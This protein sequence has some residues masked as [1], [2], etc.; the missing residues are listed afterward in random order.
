M[1]WRSLHERLA[2]YAVDGEPIGVADGPEEGHVKANSAVRGDDGVVRAG[3]VVARWSGWSLATMRPPFDAGP[4]APGAARGG[5]LPFA[6]DFAFTPRPG[7]L[8]ALRFAARYAV[9]ARV[10]DIAGGGLALDDAVADRCAITQVSYARYEPVASPM[11]L[12][13]DG[14]A[15]AALGPAEAVDRVVVRSGPGVGVDAFDAANPGY[16]THARR[17]LHRPHTSLEIAEQHKLLDGVD[18]ERAFA[19]V[20]RALAA[21][22]PGPDPADGPLPDPAAG[23][24]QVVPRLDPGAPAA[25][26]ASRDWRGPW[27][28]PDEPKPLELRDRAAGQAPVS[29][30]EQTLVVRLAAGEQLTLEL[31]SSLTEDFFDHFALRHDPSRPAAEAGR[32]PL[33]TPARTV[34][35]VH[36]VRRPLR[37]VPAATLLVSRAPEA[38]QTFAL[39]DPS[40]ALVGPAGLDA[41]S[42]AQLDV[43][44]AWKERDDDQERDIAAAPVQSLSIAPGDVALNGQLRH[45]LGDTR[46]RDITYTLSGVSRFRQYFAT[47][48]DPEAFCARTRLDTTV[49][50]LSTARPGPPLVLRARPAFTVKETVETSGGATTLRRQRLA[51]GLR[52]E[53]QRPWFTTGDGE[54]L[55]VI[56]WDHVGVAPPATLKPYVTQA[57][58]DPVWQTPD[59]A[60]WPVEARSPGSRAR[61]DGRRL[62]RPGRRCSRCPSSR[63][64][65]PIAGTQTWRCRAS[66]CRRTA[67]SWT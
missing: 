66:R 63:G 16:A 39:L 61:S 33:L 64:C 41:N 46:H 11:P 12:L 31:S 30:E 47:D 56:L 60:R 43:T 48:E 20:E 67:R 4:A 55:A 21:A 40:A 57:A 36:A 7:S 44:G 26:F 17:A 13:P 50:I 29:F 53:L 27:P 22:A 19:W 14:V 54:R 49:N 42:T 32:N 15:V 9:R 3:E 34:T 8:P 45:E 25:A 58:R 59:P 37:A 1:S 28:Q 51:G 38:G 5:G 23:G 2:T 18:D 6:F 24:V 65:M 35:L 52:V 62:S 10:V